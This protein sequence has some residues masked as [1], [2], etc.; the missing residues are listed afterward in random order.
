MPILSFLTLLLLSML[1]MLSFL[2]L[3][4]GKYKSKEFVLG[5]PFSPLEQLMGVLPSLSSALVPTPLAE[6]M[7]NAASPIAAFYPLHFESD[8]NGKKNSWEAVVKIPFIDEELLLK[9]VHEKYA[10][11]SVQERARNAFGDA[12]TFEYI[13]GKTCALVAP[14]AGFPTLEDCH[15]HEHVIKV[16]D[17]P[18]DSLRRGLT[19][20]VCLGSTGPA[21]FPS[22]VALPPRLELEGS[23]QHLD[24]TVF[25]GAVPS[26]ALTLGLILMQLEATNNDQRNLQGNCD[27]SIIS[28]HVHLS[29]SFLFSR[30]SSLVSRL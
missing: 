9:T 13:P 10:L 7:T 8:L 21:T 19:P 1:S 15:V 27:A 26:K 12:V 20:G 22:L 16:V 4:L 23:L 17:P 25:P 3:C 2:L 30:L 5:K 24:V 28:A 11:L 29:I 14:S 18:R 6:L